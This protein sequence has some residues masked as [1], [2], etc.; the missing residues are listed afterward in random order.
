MRFIKTQLKGAYEIETEPFTDNRGSFSRLFCKREL[1]KIGHQKEIA[2]V[3]HSYSR[4]KGTLRGMHYQIPPSAEIKIVK[5]IR[6][7]V[8]DV[9]VDLRKGSPTFLKWYGTLLTEDNNKMLYIPEGFAH[10]YITLKDD[11]ELL[12]FDTGF[13]SAKHERGIRFD[14][15]KIGIR[16]PAKA[17]IISDK[18]RNHELLK[19]GFAGISLP[20]G[21]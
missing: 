15:P 8:F 7:K 12:Y 18:D 6:G 16:W 1:A 11:T 13:Y 5:C 10:G 20:G 4:K 3:N 21:K 2:Q 19:D 9:M 17:T 14:D